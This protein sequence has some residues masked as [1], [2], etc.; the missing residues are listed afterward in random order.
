MLIH[1]SVC[2]YVIYLIC[3]SNE[4]NKQISKYEISE[5]K[6]QRVKE[7]KNEVTV[8]NMSLA[9]ISLMKSLMAY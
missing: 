6:E 5:T 3:V 1:L 2:M 8:F 4:T 9:L 7:L